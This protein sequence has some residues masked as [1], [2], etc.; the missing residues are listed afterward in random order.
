MC[1]LPANYENDWTLGKAI[2]KKGIGLHTGKEVEITL[3]PTKLKG[4]HIS[5]KD[6]P[7]DLITVNTDQI[8]NTPLCTTLDLGAKSIATVEHLLA[9]L[10]G[11]GLTHV[12]IIS[13]G[14]EIPL[15]DGSSL[16]WV[17][18]IQDAGLIKVKKNNKSFPKISKPIF[19]NQGQSVIS[20]IPSDKLK[21]T[22][23][24]DF[25]YK[26]IGQQIFSLE[27]CPKNFVKE[28]APAR[29]FGFADQIDM[30]KQSGLIQGGSLDNA[31]V[32]NGDSWLNPP[33]RFQNEPV[34]HKILDLIGDL[35]IVGLP[36]AHI[37]VYRGSHSLHAELAAALQK[38][39]L[40][41]KIP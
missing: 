11:C 14:N 7:N 13:S 37:L 4:F 18:A 40:N 1:N 9:A 8:R 27:L 17:E 30:L 21:I 35:A 41:S 6:K 15:L 36:K 26:A 34:R 19:I 3:V 28:I 16:P 22:G 33:L 24:V 20:A 12:Q 23:I 38:N 29:T 5:F 31:L 10:I 25:T 2:V 32:C 39:V